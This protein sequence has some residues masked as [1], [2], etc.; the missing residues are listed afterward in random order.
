MRP[1]RF[2]LPVVWALALVLVGR[3][4][5]AAQTADTLA[6]GGKKGFG[7]YTPGTGFK[8]ADTEHGD[9]NFKLFTYLRYLNQLGTDDS[10]TDAFGNTKPVQRRQDIQ[11]QKINVQ[12]L[13][14]L[15]SPK[16]R[17]LAYVWTSNTSLGQVSQ[18]VVG[19][20][21][22]YR[23]NEHITLGAGIASLPGVRSTEGNFPYWLSVDNRLTA[24]EFFRPSY[25]TGLWA[26]GAVVQGL[27]YYVMV[28]N[29]LSQFG[30]DAGQMDNSMDTWA[31]SLNW[32]PTTG[33]FGKTGGFGDFEQ[34]E[35]LATRIGAHYTRSDE[36]RQ[37]Q[38]NTESV[39]NSQIRLSDGNVIFT[40]GLFG[41]GIVVTDVTYH[42]T[43]LD[44]G[45]KYRGLSLEAEYYWRLVDNV[46]GLNADGLG[47]FRDHGFQVQASAMVVPKL[48]QVY[49]GG[50]K[51]FGE[52]GDPSEFRA[53]VN[54]FPFR[55]EVIRWNLQWIQL[56]KSPVGS[57]SHPYTVGSNGSVF[58][59]DFMVNF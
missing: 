42:M 49:A 29:N 21:L 22:Q 39:E 51:I 15:L 55:N 58:Q 31:F 17:Y 50:A 5:V 1:S 34:H 54:W 52:Y 26:K 44:A 19:G 43:S 6:K 24:D 40:P 32:K 10:Y 53:G 16:F 20:N 3:S 56:N 13:G 33:E 46:R 35:R 4:P 12:F 7:T 14:W 9:L 45:A 41:E 57:L 28:G 27:D 11:L 47:E 38:P 30:V 48:V 8:I 59:T 18:V 37:S 25:T 36:N 23:F 2:L